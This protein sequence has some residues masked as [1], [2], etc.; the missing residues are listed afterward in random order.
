MLMSEHELIPDLEIVPEGWN[1]VQLKEILKVRHGKSQ[2]DVVS[3]EGIF[4]I[5]G[6][7]GQIG[8][9]TKYLYDKPSVLIGRKGTIDAP[10]YI[11][12]PFWTIDTLFY[13]EINS[14]AFP[15]FV[16]YKFQTIDWYSYNEASGVPSLNSSTIEKIEIILPPLLEQQRISRALQHLDATLEVARELE[17]QARR[18]REAA[19]EQLLT[20]GKKI[21]LG[22]LTGKHGLQTGPFGSQLH[23]AEYTNLGIPVVMPRDLLEGTISESAI[24]RVPK[25]VHDRLTKHH[26]QIGD[27]VFSRRGN[28]ER[29]LLSAKKIGFVERGVSEQELP[30]LKFSQG[31]FFSICRNQKYHN[32]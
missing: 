28:L 22:E 23:A 29:L 19:K 16:Y 5:F 25:E 11:E 7:G 26:L 4:P 30:I 17:L 3:L 24:A 12:T 18:V 13:T 15:K 32:G 8:K 31:T 21:T 20:R 10:R 6:S 1:V 9:A 14:L 27:V 2:H